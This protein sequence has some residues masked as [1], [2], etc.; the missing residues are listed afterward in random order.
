MTKHE[1]ENLIQKAAQAYYSGEPIMSDRR[2][3][4]YVEWLRAIDPNSEVLKKTGWGYTPKVNANKVEHIHGGMGSIDLKPRSIEDIP[5]DFKS[6]VRITPKLDGLSGVMHFR[7]GVFV[8]GL[9]RGNGIVGI[10]KTDKFNALIDRYGGTSVPKGVDCEIRGE[11]VI[12]NNNWSEMLANGTEK[13]NA[14]NAAS[15]IVNADRII[16]DFKYLDFVPY[17]FIYLRPLPFVF[18]NGEIGRIQEWLPGFPKIEYNYFDDSY[19]ENDLLNCYINWRQTWP[20][21][22]VVITQYDVDIDAASISHRECAY[23]FDTLKKETV[24]T[25]IKWQQSRLN[26]FKPVATLE[27]I[28]LGG[29]TIQNV[30]CHNAATVENNHIVPGTKVLILKSGDVIPYIEEVVE[31]NNDTPLDFPSI[32]PCCGKPLVRKGVDI[33]CENN[34]CPNLDEQSLLVWVNNIGIVDGFGGI[35]LKKYFDRFNVRSINDVYAL[36]LTKLQLSLVNEGVTS[37]KFYEIIKNLQ[38]AIIPLKNA[39]LGLNI[40]RLGEVS[41]EKLSKDINFIKMIKDLIDSNFDEHQFEDNRFTYYDYMYNVVGDATANS[42]L[43]HFD[44]L[45]NLRYLAGRINANP[46]NKVETTMTVCIT[47][48]IPGYSRKDF[49]SLHKSKG[50]DVKDDVT[51]KVSYLITNTPTTSTSKNK[52]ADELGI[53][54]LTVAEFMQKFSIN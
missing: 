38:Q 47:G 54:K 17:K 50:N 9:T 8:R 49:V 11:F 15:G 19:T 1:L 40:P 51:K 10:D 26:V 20:C 7:D 2:F 13:K 42:I 28:E 33:V 48:S 25:G 34:N 46:E 52:K 53:P 23:K 24:V 4:Q 21:D 36:D 37:V 30:T 41:S 3:D 6:R 27:P 44:R 18:P 29:S 32:C 12:S 14:R 39:L 5:E 16:E 31:T 22:G 43:D 45:S 35:L